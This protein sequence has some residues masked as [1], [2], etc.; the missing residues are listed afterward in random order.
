MKK[1]E[2]SCDQCGKRTCT[3]KCHEK[4]EERLTINQLIIIIFDNQKQ[5]YIRLQLI[6]YYLLSILE[7]LPY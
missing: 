3:K 7:A 5:I 4:C 6:L 1:C 2:K